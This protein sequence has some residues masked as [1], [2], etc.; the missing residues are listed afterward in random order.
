MR[1]LIEFRKSQPSLLRDQFLTG[2]PQDQR[3]VPDVS[4]FESTG[5]PINWD[6]PDGTLVCWLAKPS[7]ANDPDGF[8]RDILILFNGTPESRTFTMPESVRGTRWRLF[9]D[10]QLPS[11]SDIFPDLDGPDMPA[12]RHIPMTYRSC[13]VYVSDS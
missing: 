13:A 12:T 7:P 2:R 10:T 9:L 1:G 5:L 4:W 8:G 6:A 11:P 3:G